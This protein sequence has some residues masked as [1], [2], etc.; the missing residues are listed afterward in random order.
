M[1]SKAQYDLDKKKEREAEMSPQA[2]ISP[3]KSQ[4]AGGGLS[5]AFGGGTKRLNYNKMRSKTKP[6]DNDE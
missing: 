1:R 5:K 6:L 2:S 4:A 3:L